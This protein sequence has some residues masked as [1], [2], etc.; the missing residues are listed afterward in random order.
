VGARKIRVGSWL[1]ALAILCLG[2]GGGPAALGAQKGTGEEK[3]EAPRPP[4]GGHPLP[5]RRVKPEAY[6]AFAKA[7]LLQTRSVRLLFEAQQLRASDRELAQEKRR[8][9]AEVW[10]EALEAFKHA[11]ALDPEGVVPVRELAFALATRG[12]F[13]EALPYLE[14]T[15]E[16]APEDFA[17]RLELALLYEQAERFA[18]ARATYRQVIDQA[19]ANQASWL[20]PELYVHLAGVTGR[21]EGAAGALAVFVEALTVCPEA[22]PVRTG[23]ER[24]IERTRAEEGLADKLEKAVP[25]KARGFAYSY[26]LGR[27]ALVRRDWGGAAAE[28]GRAIGAKADFW[29]AYLYRCLALSEAGQAEEALKVLAQLPSGELAA[30]K[31][32][33]LRGAILFRAQRYQE[34]RQALEQAVQVA[35][36]DVGARYELAGTYEKLGMLDEAIAALRVNLGLKPDDADTLNAL[37]YFLALKNAEL[38]EAEKLVRKALE[39]DPENGAY[40]DSLGWVLFRQGKGDEALALLTKAAEK[41]ADPVVYEHLGDVYRERGQ[42][43]EAARWWERALQLDAGAAGVREKLRAVRPEGSSPAGQ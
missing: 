6:G 14:R 2:C 40:L 20:L 27:V 28:L 23:T 24:A 35:P 8:Q 32:E 39:Q 12:D 43:E 30:G 5:L 36:S 19:P 3:A 41:L 37:G 17:A 11:I 31:A 34:A 33:S 18:D 21:V 25:T 13:E 10:A 7:V 26:V 9:A 16:L 22:E 29:P 42:T 15:V 1:L 4:V 38:E